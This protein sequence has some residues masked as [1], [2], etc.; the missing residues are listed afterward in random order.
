[1]YAHDNKMPAELTFHDLERDVVVWTRRGLP[2]AGLHSRAGRLV[3]IEFRRFWR[4]VPG[5]SRKTWNV[6]VF[7][8]LDGRPDDLIHLNA[9]VV[10]F[11]G[12]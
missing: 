7:V 8:A 11:L 1:M 4:D 9:G 10:E 2:D 3:R 6:G 5:T 12:A